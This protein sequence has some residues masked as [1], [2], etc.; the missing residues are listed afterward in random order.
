MRLGPQLPLTRGAAPGVVSGSPRPWSRVPRPVSR[1]SAPPVPLCRGSSPP[2]RVCR[3]SSPPVPLSLGERGNYGRASGLERLLGPAGRHDAVA[4]RR[5]SVARQPGRAVGTGPRQRGAL[6][7]GPQ[8]AG[9]DAVHHAVGR[10]RPATTVE[11]ELPRRIG[12]L[13]GP[14]RLERGRRRIVGFGSVRRNPPYRPGAGGAG[15]RGGGGFARRTGH[16]D[17]GAGARLLRAAPSA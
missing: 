16:A 5:R 12:R 8:R 4:S 13:S 2:V 9:P 15:R 3:G 7:S 10:L 17:G 6:G 14:E 1:R 11:R